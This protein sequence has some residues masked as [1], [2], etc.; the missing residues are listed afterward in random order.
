MSYVHIMYELT[1]A[2]LPLNSHTVEE[3]RN[4]ITEGTGVGERYS[5]CCS[6]MGNSDGA[7]GGSQES[8]LRHERV[9]G[10]DENRAIG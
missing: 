1:Y 9:G 6:H 5:T 2:G 10:W 4:K 3:H 8:K 7:A